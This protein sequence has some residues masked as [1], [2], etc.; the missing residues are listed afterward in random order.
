MKDL[1]LPSNASEPGVKNLR[2]QLAQKVKRYTIGEEIFNS[3]SHGIG[4]LLSIAALV[5]L[6][7]FSVGKPG[8]YL[9]SA[10]VYSISMFLEYTS[11][12]LYHA[13]QH[14]KAKAVFRVFDH[15][16][17]YFLIAGTY[18]PYALISL[19]DSGG[20]DIFA[21]VWAIAFAGI[22]LEVFWREKPKWVSVLIYL[23]MGWLVVFKVPDLVAAL[24]TGGLILLVAGGLAY[25][26]GTIFYLLKKV[27]YMHSIW[28]LFVLAGSILQFFSI[29]IYI[30]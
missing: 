14:P 9:L 29:L 30:Y 18:T 21:A 22:F 10:L 19:K 26:I 15:V 6:V 24:P 11:S 27:R 23:I 12:T 25:S 20:I 2:A 8:I 13:I 17:I 3:V 5:L 16:C 28:H 1:S 7:V 4:A